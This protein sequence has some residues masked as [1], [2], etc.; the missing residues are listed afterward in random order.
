RAAR[1]SGLR[2]ERERSRRRFAMHPRFRW[3]L[4]ALPALSAL[5]TAAHAFCGLYVAGGESKLFNH[6]SQVVLV[7]DQD[8]TVLTMA[9]DYQGDAKEFALVVPV[10]VVLQKGQIHVGDSVLVARLDQYSAPRLVEYYDPDPC[11]TGPAA[12]RLEM[13]SS[14]SRQ[15][16]SSARM[17]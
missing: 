15:R 13:N 10:P 7:R 16:I 2:P 5:A 8:R 9:S 14:P 6:K 1:S 11:P 4:P 12:T 3:L 17:A